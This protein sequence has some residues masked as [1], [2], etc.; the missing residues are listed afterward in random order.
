MN[1]EE[2]F[3]WI[4]QPLREKVVEIEGRSIRLREMTEEQRTEYELML[5]DKKGKADLKKARRAM[6][7]MMIVDND[8]NRIVDDES[9]LRNMP[10]GIAGE[11]FAACLELNRYEKD[12]IDD[13]IKNSE[14]V[15]A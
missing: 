8:G 14:P 10:G 12:E 6:L 3:S 13:L 7:A 11:L 9:Q 15:P 5:Q 1:R 4:A 2:F